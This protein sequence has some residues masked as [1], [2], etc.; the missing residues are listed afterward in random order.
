MDVAQW[1]QGILW[2]PFVKGGWEVTPNPKIGL[3]TMFSSAK[4]G[5]THN[6]NIFGTEID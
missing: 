5:Y 2:N 4:G 3:K 1:S 6:V